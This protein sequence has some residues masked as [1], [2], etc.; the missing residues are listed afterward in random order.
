MS[1]WWFLL[2]VRVHTTGPG[3]QD[4]PGT[5][6]FLFE[7]TFTYCGACFDI[8]RDMA[9]SSSSAAATSAVPQQQMMQ[10]LLTAIQGLQGSVE[11]MKDQIKT[12]LQLKT[13]WVSLQQVLDPLIL[14]EQQGLITISRRLM[15]HHL[16]YLI[17]L[18][19][20]IC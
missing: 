19:V 5:H 14:Q 10:Q 3:L 2:G 15:E 11:G 17:N 1:F 8:F 18:Q 16:M 4:T 13:G 20:L 9:T 6:P 7:L 12:K